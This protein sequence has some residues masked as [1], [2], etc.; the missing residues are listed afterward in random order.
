MMLPS[1]QSLALFAEESAL[2]TVCYNRKVGVMAGDRMACI[3]ENKH[4]VITKVFKV[5]GALVGFS[6]HSDVA[7]AILRWIS[8]G[9]KDEDWP[10]L[11]YE[12]TDCSVLVVEADGVVKMYERYPIPI[13]MEQDL[14]AIG[15]GRDFALAAM[16]LGCDPIKAVE[17]A[18]VFDCYTGSGVDA[19]CLGEAQ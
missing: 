7:V 15:S 9:R 14:H 5:E 8:G 12:N 17:V 13:V 2:T 11:Q 1:V 6:G 16:H 18:S 3:G 19:V 10:E 4:G